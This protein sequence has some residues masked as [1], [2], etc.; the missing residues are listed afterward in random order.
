MGASSMFPAS[1]IA[2]L[3]VLN[4]A[5]ASDV[6][7]LS[8]IETGSHP[9]ALLLDKSQSRLF[10]ANASSD[11]V[12]IVDTHSDQVVHTILLRRKSQRTLPARRPL[13]LPSSPDQKKLYVTLADMNAVGVIDPD[14]AELDGYIPVGW[15][16]T[17]VAVAPEGNGC[18][19]SMPG[20]ST[21]GIPT[22]HREAPNRC[23]PSRCWR[24]I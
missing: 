10:V 15:Y 1:V 17:A 3:Y 13:A 11:T 4:T 9:V 8:K 16:P 7:L 24:E 22:P 6:K 21:R 18:W 20:D 23:R 2:P 19:C 12:S 14:D 5:E